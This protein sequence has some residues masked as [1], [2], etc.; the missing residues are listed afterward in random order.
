MLVDVLGELLDGRDAAR[1]AAGEEHPASHD[2]NRG[3]AGSS[4]VASDEAS[5]TP[6]D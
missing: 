2:A 6:S 5:R 1:E 3:A 4:V